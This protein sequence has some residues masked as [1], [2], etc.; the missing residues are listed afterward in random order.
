V[1]Q[2]DQTP[3]RKPIEFEVISLKRIAKSRVQIQDPTD[4]TPAGFFADKLEAEDVW[5][6]A[7]R[8]TTQL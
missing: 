4:L 7:M 8:T 3:R 1:Y 2:V 5:M 6:A